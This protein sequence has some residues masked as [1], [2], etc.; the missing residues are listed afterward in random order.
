MSKIEQYSAAETASR[1][2]RI[3]RGALNVLPMP[4][5]IENDRKGKTKSSAPR[6]SRATAKTAR[7]SP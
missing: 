5:S 6:S 1:F 7:R 3:L 2:K 4:H